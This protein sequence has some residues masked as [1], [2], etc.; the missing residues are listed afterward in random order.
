MAQMER[1]TDRGHIPS[2]SIAWHRT[3]EEFRWTDADLH[4]CTD[5][6]VKPYGEDK[7]RDREEARLLEQKVLEKRSVPVMDIKN[8]QK[9]VRKTFSNGDSVVDAMVDLIKSGTVSRFPLMRVAEQ[10]G[11][12]DLY[13]ADNRRAFMF[14]VVA[15][16]LFLDRIDVNIVTWTTEFDVKLRQHRR[17]GDVWSTDARTIERVRNKVCRQAMSPCED[18]SESELEASSDVDIMEVEKRQKSILARLERALESESTG[19]RRVLHAC[20]NPHTGG[21]QHQHCRVG[22]VGSCGPVQDQSQ[23]ALGPVPSQNGFSS[24]STGSTRTRDASLWEIGDRLQ[25]G[26]TEAELLDENFNAVSRLQEIVMQAVRPSGFEDLKRNVEYREVNRDGEVWLRPVVCGA[27]FE[28]QRLQ[29]L[30]KR[31]RKAARQQTARA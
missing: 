17:W 13:S 26:V 8:T 1:P 27:E 22:A 16:L 14:K 9:T 4:Q 11:T 10:P 2:S 29:N 20:D 5:A 25:R 30:C 7:A 23:T 15:P 3:F 19:C 21:Q 31:E 18:S 28:G 6:S 12:G 24:P